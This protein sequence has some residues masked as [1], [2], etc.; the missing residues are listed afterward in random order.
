MDICEYG[1]CMSKLP[2]IQLKQMFDYAGVNS[3]ME[4]QDCAVL[5]ETELLFTTDFG[6]LVGK[7]CREAGK[8]AA[9]NALSDIYARG[10]VAL[11][12]T[13]ILV[14]GRD[15]EAG[16]KELLLS[17]VI[18]T[19]KQE[20]V[21]VVGGHTILGRQTIVGLAVIGKKGERFFEKNNCNIGDILL[22][23]KKIGSGIALRAYY[24]GL[25]DEEKYEELN[26]VMTTSNHLKKEFLTLPYIHAMTDITGFG[27]MG[28]LAEMLKEDQGATL[29]L[30]KIPYIKSILKFSAHAL[31]NN[32]IHDNLDYARESHN[33]RWHLDTI[34]KLALADPQTNGPILISADRKIMPYIEQFGFIDIGIITKGKE[35][36]LYEG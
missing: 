6:P 18:E 25:L 22:I 13:V 24:S 8:I 3:L 1:G 19:C 12:A 29:Y 20:G 34:E 32:T 11:Y 7:N 36:V 10:G 15:L 27:L 17:S 35:I 23:N 9:L 31:D 26:R 5:P 28:H 33:I 21:E 2:A 30:N 14:L 16:E 4:F